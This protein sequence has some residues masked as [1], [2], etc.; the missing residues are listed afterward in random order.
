MAERRLS[1][2]EALHEQEDALP[3]ETLV[4]EESESKPAPR[5]QGVKLGG[6]EFQLPEEFAASL[7]RELQERRRQHEQELHDVRQQLSA[8]QQ[9]WKELQGV[10]QP[11]RVTDQ[12]TEFF[13]SPMENLKRMRDE[14]KEEIRQETAAE[15]RIEKFWGDFYRE[16]EDLEG[17]TWVVD[18]VLATSPDLGQMN[19]REAAVELAKRARERAMGVAQRLGGGRGRGEPVTRFESGQGRRYDGGRNDEPPEEPTSLT[20]EIRALRG[21]R[22]R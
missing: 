11:P 10:F 7:Q 6:Q 21:G 5:T 22:S 20:Q 1:V 16:N 4:P 19:A 14:L 18:A 13:K 12:D 2:T 17:M 15:R 3:E 8:A 9:Q